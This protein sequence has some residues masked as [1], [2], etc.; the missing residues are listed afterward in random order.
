MRLLGYIL[1]KFSLNA[2][3]TTQK[4]ESPIAAAQ[5]IGLRLHPVSDSS[6]PEARGMPQTL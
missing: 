1:A 6:T 4:L 5:N 2:F 3:D